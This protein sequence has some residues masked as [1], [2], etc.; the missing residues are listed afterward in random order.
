MPAARPEPLLTVEQ[1]QQELRHVH[2]H[3]GTVGASQAAERIT[4]FLRPGESLLVRRPFGWHLNGKHLPNQAEHFERDGVCASLRMEVVCDFGDHVAVVRACA[5]DR[6]REM[7]DAILGASSPREE[8][9][10]G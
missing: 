3:T 9:P 6:E 2:K 8:P 10:R 4:I 5:E 1:V 7:Q